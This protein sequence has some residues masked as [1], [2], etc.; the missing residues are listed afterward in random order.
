MI[1]KKNKKFFFL[2]LVAGLFIAIGFLEVRAEFR[3]LEELLAELAKKEAQIKNLEERDQKRREEEAEGARCRE[4]EDARDSRIRWAGHE[5]QLAA[6]VP[7]AQRVE[8][9]ER[10][11]QEVVNREIQELEQKATA[12]EAAR[13]AAYEAEKRWKAA[14]AE[15][16]RLDREVDRAMAAYVKEIKLFG[17]DVKRQELKEKAAALK[18]ERDAAYEAEQRDLPMVAA[19]ERL[20]REANDAIDALRRAEEIV[21]ARAKE[22]YERTEG[23]KAFKAQEARRE[24][25]RRQRVLENEAA[26]KKSWEMEMELENDSCRDEEGRSAND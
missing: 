20:R 19:I 13:D 4:K 24:A 8:K 21:K 6:T 9:E 2:T 5:A 1:S 26:R 12:A 10:L 16:E 14:G 3:S 18:I 17:N 11:I 22:R 25:E 7:V 15:K 23:E